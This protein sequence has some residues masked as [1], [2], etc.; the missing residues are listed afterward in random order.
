MTAKGNPAVGGLTSLTTL[1]PFS[2]AQIQ[3][4]LRHMEGAGHL[5]KF[6]VEL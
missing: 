5:G 4:A 6:V 2:G 3:E 1:S